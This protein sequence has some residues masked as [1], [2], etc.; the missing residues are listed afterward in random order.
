[1]SV[2]QP[3]TA[4]RP[5]DALVQ[6]WLLCVWAL[7][8]AMVIVGGITRLTESGL[9]ITRWEPVSG[10]LPPLSEAA[11]QAEF[12]HYRAS[13]QFRDVNAWMQLADFKRIYF[14]EYVHRLLG[15][16]IGFAVL[17]PWLV[18]LA[19]KRLS[20]RFAWQTAGVFVLGGLQGAL[21]WY[22][23][24]S[25]LIDEPRVSHFRLAAHLLLAFLVGQLVL[26]LALD[27]GS[28]KAAPA[29]VD[30]GDRVHR[31]IAR[32]TVALIALLALQTLYGAFMAGLRAGYYF[33]SFPDMN[34]HFAPTPF[35]KA[36][37]L[38]ENLLSYPP[39]IHW[40]HRALAFLALGCATALWIYVQRIPALPAVRR[41]AML[42]AVA[43]F[44][45]LNL[46]AITVLS[47]VQIGWAVA[48]QGL[49][50]LLLSAATLL[51]HRA[52]HAAR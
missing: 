7:V 34:G 10:A 41:A 31:R 23:V 8:L 12:E 46:G 48:H 14:W 38:A 43:V 49:A 40:I 21:G 37:T 30:T 3:E 25:G 42:L 28:A 18:L 6:R 52:R 19:R 17:L 24:K 39:A 5:A 4:P 16:S 45:Q 15:R 44:L 51:L 26:W 29:P 11:W 13:P 22:M 2:D 33:G 27:A 35:F 36:A 20:A 9:S 50:Y 32:A 1:M 47:R